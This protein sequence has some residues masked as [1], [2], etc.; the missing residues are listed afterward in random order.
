MSRFPDIAD[1]NVRPC[2]QLS[3]PFRNLKS[4]SRNA[5]PGASPR[6]PV[7]QRLVARI[8]KGRAMYTRLHFGLKFHPCVIGCAPDYHRPRRLLIVVEV[9]T[10]VVPFSGFPDARHSGREHRRPA[11]WNSLQHFIRVH[12]FPSSPRIDIASL[13]CEFDVKPSL[14]G[15]ARCA[16]SK[17]TDVPGGRIPSVLF[18]CVPVRPHSLRAIS[19]GWQ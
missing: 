18:S 8:L 16:P 6:R 14:D 3:R 17:K 10:Q 7:F 12:S 15:R 11:F 19:Q 2:P 5:A 1:Y 4:S 9:L 13:Y